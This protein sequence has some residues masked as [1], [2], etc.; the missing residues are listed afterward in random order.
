MWFWKINSCSCIRAFVFQYLWSSIMDFACHLKPAVIKVR[1][2]T[3]TIFLQ[4]ILSLQGATS[5]IDDKGCLREFPGAGDMNLAF[6]TQGGNPTCN[7]GDSGS[8]IGKQLKDGRS[9]TTSTQWPLSYGL[10]PITEYA[11]LS[12]F[13]CCIW[14]RWYQLGVQDVRS[15]PC[16]TEHPDLYADVT[17][18][19]E[20]IRT[21]VEANP[22]SS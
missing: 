14:F 10:P 22:W 4:L 16:T 1:G 18:S 7:R 20:F 3:Y 15:I 11:S 9:V 13:H 19:M 5:V 12:S 8:F 2:S 21:H 17:T 6:C